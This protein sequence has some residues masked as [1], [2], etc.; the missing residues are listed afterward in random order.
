M[1]ERRRHSFRRRIDEP[2]LGARCGL[3]PVPEPTVGQPGGR[4]RTTDQRE[5]GASSS[6][7][8]LFGVGHGPLGGA[9][10]AV[11]R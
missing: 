6:C 4:D 7:A 1:I 5:L 3:G 2:E 10:G 8:I 9:S 11:L